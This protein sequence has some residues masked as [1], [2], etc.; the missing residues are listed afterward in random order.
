MLKMLKYFEDMLN[1]FKCSRGHVRN[2][3]NLTGLYKWVMSFHKSTKR[4]SLVRQK[5]SKLVPAYFFLFL[6]LE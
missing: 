4:V 6:E 5:K 3:R 1:V 2:Y